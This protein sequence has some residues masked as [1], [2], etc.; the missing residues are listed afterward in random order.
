MA[1]MAN[2]TIIPALVRIFLFLRFMCVRVDIIAKSC[3]VPDYVVKG[4]EF[5]AYSGKMYVNGPV[6]NIGCVFPKFV[7]DGRAG[8]ICA[9]VP[10]KQHEQVKFLSGKFYI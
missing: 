6:Q 2:N 4:T 5:C 10:G 8:K 1:A 9:R 3:L 7:D